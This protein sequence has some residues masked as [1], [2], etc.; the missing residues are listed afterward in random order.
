MIKA[1]TSSESKWKGKVFEVAKVETTRQNENVLQ[2][3][4]ENDTYWV[5]EEKFQ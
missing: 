2:I 3:R 1:Y 5:R 4:Q